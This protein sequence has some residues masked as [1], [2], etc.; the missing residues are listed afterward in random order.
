MKRRVIGLLLVMVCILSANSVFAAEKATQGLPNKIIRDGREFKLYEPSRRSNSAEPDFSATSDQFK[1][2]RDS[3]RVIASD[4]ALYID[5]SH[6]H[7]GDQFAA[8]YVQATAPKF[9]ARAEV[10][11]NGRLDTTGTNNKNRGDTAEAAS[12]L[13]VYIKES[14]YA[15]IFYNWGWDL[16]GVASDNI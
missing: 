7:G 2:L 5:Y 14:R 12:Y 15:R 3:Y 11:D 8:G 1:M 6:G 4:V 16:A 10:W 13:S 9:T